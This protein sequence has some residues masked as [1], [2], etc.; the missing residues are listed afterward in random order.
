MRE[1]ESLAAL[2][3]TGKVNGDFGWQ[4]LLMKTSHCFVFKICKLLW[5]EKKDLCTRV[6]PFYFCH[7]HGDTHYFGLANEIC[8]KRSWSGKVAESAVA[9]NGWGC[10]R[11]GGISCGMEKIPSS[12]GSGRLSSA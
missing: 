10:V 8:R 2:A 9:R 5:G 7:Q 3:E 11:P 6:N 12:L 4:S 1:N